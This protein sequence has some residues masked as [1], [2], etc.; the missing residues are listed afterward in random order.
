MREAV[1]VAGTRTAV[2]RSKK[3]STRNWRSD[4]MAAAVIKKLL[5]DTE[6]LDPSE[7]DD[8]IPTDAEPFT[9]SDNDVIDDEELKQ[10]LIQDF[11]N[12]EDLDNDPDDITLD[13]E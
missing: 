9:E 12:K 11:K 3:G 1:I 5:E 8:V 6:A 10:D 4:E 13:D 7:I 2:G